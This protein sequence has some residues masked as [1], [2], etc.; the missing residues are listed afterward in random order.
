M[1][2]LW[3]VCGL[4]WLCV[5]AGCASPY[6]PV[7]FTGGYSEALLAPN[8]VSI[9]FRG[10]ACTS[11][12]RAND[13]A[14]LRA[15][16]FTLE[17][18]YRYFAIIQNVSMIRTAE[19]E[20]LPAT[21]HTTGSGQI[22]GRFYGNQYRGQMDYSETSTYTSATTVPIPK[23]ASCVVIQ[24]F[25]GKP[26]GVSAFDAAPLA[27]SLRERYHMKPS[28]IPVPPETPDTAEE[29]GRESDSQQAG[30]S[31][32][33]GMFTHLLPQTQGDAESQDETKE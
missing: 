14:L 17:H 9:T 30:T 33:K 19:M 13:F 31:P 4:C 3:R 24:C 16:E 7:G 29:A 27:E 12:A 32:R 18:N 10:N 28:G 20:L 5:L 1:G 2:H 25:A 21:S 23:P 15:A 11:S 6:Q 22:Q 8:A 26:D